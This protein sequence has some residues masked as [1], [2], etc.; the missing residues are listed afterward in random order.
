MDKRVLKTRSAIFNAVFDLSTEK[1]LDKI[2][3]IELCERAG[4][5]K[6]TFYLHYNSIDDCFKKCFDFFTSKVLS[7]SNDI[8]YTAAALAPEKTVDMVLDVVEKNMLLITKFKNSVIY[9]G[10][11][12]S[13]KEKFVKAICDGN[14]FNVDS[15]YHQ[16]AKVTF[17]VGGCLDAITQ[18]LPHYDRAELR[19]IMIDVIKRKN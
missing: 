9:D 18:P 12:R 7:L 16:V 15:N 2:S 14:G 3:V 17:L 13:L 19:R 11:I 10:A 5:N 8:N 4:I 6:S 1:E